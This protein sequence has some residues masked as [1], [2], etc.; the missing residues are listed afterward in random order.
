MRL[1]ALYTDPSIYRPMGEQ[2]PRCCL[3]A[4]HRCWW[5]RGRLGAPPPWRRRTPQ[6]TSSSQS[7]LPLT[8]SNAAGLFI[9]SS[10]NVATSF[11]LWKKRPLSASKGCKAKDLLLFLSLV[12][13]FLLSWALV[14]LSGP[15]AWALSSQLEFWGRV[16][17]S[18][19]P[20]LWTL[21]HAMKKGWKLWKEG[22]FCF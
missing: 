3:P 13:V 9:A 2:R 6:Q 10:L 14:L 16:T 21:W 17:V 19:R 20:L 12:C 4:P 1:I 5:R 15:G 7:K 18:A 11:N 8:Y 22:L